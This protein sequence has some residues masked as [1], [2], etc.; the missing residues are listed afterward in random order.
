MM[1][2][3][4]AT[5]KIKIGKTKNL[6]METG[7]SVTR[8]TLMDF[9]I[10]LTYFPSEV[11]LSCGIAQR[12]SLPRIFKTLRR[13]TVKNFSRSMICHVLDVLYG[14]NIEQE[15]MVNAKLA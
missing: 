2:K 9:C 13:G 7:K 14:A 6:T 8:V 12:A 15:R 3:K 10:T 5:M 4:S 11:A 1:T